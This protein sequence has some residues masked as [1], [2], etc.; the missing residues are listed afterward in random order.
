[1]HK[2]LLRLAALVL[3]LSGPAT[4]QIAILQIH[5][6]EGE[7]AVHPPGSRI[8]R[9]LAVEVTDETGR[10]VAGAAVSFHL[11]DDGPTG[12]FL[13]GLR[14][15]VSTTDAAGRAA[16]HGMVLNRT[17]GRFQIRVVASKEQARAGMFSLQYIAE[18]HSGEAAASPAHAPVAPQTGISHAGHT[19][20]LM[21]AAAVGAGAAAGI[22]SAARKGGNSAAAPA[23]PP[24][25]TL[26]IGPPSST[27]VKP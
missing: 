17:A 16:L 7:G 1:V 22:L 23:A 26:T 4:A 8:S 11:P 21:V 18:P 19:R 24:A 14:T 15:E 25:S 5:V 6:I 13:N 2:I 10:P 20:W 3:A 12:V 27:V 9:A